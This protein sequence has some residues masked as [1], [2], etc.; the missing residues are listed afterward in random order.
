[1][2][3]AI[4]TKDYSA[5]CEQHPSREAAEQA[6]VDFINDIYGWGVQSFGDLSNESPLSSGDNY[7]IFEINLYL[8]PEVYAFAKLMEQALRAEDSARGG[9]SW[10]RQTLP[11][12]ILPHLQD[13]VEYI[14]DE[15]PRIIRDRNFDE[16]REMMRLD[17]MASQAIHAANYCM[18]LADIAG[19][20]K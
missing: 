9:N 17:H 20:L 4:L 5:T 6:V 10:Q 15:M 18:M 7:E 13:K 8:R 14:V 16:I 3:I 12:E 1:M 11:E 2:F 19:R